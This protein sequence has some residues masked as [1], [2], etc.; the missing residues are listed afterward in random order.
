MTSDCVCCAISPGSQFADM[1]LPRVIPVLL[2]TESGIVKTRCF[3]DARY[4]GDPINALRVF[5]E[6]QVDEIVLL[7]IEATAAGREPDY[8]RV[9]DLASE[10]FMPMAYGGGISSAVQA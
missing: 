8:L 7:D 1:L 5:N 4:V 3:K 9:R 2:M 10:C 6:K